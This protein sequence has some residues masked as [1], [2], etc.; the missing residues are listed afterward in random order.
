MPGYPRPSRGPDKVLKGHK[1]GTHPSGKAQQPVRT[2]GSARLLVGQG[3]RLGEVAPWLTDPPGAPLRPL[4]RRAE[5]VS[6]VLQPYVFRRRLRKRIPL[7]Q[8]Q[9]LGRPLEQ[10]LDQR[11]EQGTVPLRIQ[12]G[13]PHL[14]V[15]PRVEGLDEARAPRRVAGFPPQ[16]IGLPL[17]PVTA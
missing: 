15:E 7:Q 9:D 1:N 6:E 8:P 14:P 3:D 11:L 17:R 13:E 4:L 12:R 2:P 5:K 16:R 10:M